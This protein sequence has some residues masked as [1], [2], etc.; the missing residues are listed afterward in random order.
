MRRVAL[1][2]WVAA[3]VVGAAGAPALLRTRCAGC[4][5]AAMQAGGLR[6][7][8]AAD[9][10]RG[11]Y[12]GA[13]IRPGDSRGSKL[14]TLITTGVES[15]GKVLKMPPA[16]AALT[17]AQVAE[18]RAW[19][20]AGARWPAGEGA[21]A[22]AKPAPASLW[23]LAPLRRP[24]LPVVA[25]RNP[26]DAFV[27]ARLNREGV[28][29]SP[30][31]PRAVLARRLHLDLTGLLPSPEQVQAFVDDAAP[32]AYEKVVDELLRSPHYGEKW[33]RHWLDLA[34]YAD[35]E[36]GV[37]DYARPFAW[38]YRDWVM[39]AFNRDLPFDRFTVEQ[40]AGDLLP[41]ATL[42]QK[43]ATGFHRQTVTSREGG[44]DLER[45]RFDQLVDR[46][47][48]T[49]AVFLGLTVGCAQCHDHKYD[50]ITQKDFYRL[51]AY[52]EN[53]AEADLEAPLP[54]ELG[55]YRSYAAA[56]REQ[57]RKLIAEYGIMPAE[58]DWEA[59]MRDA[60]ARPG[61]RPQWDVAYDAMTKLVDHGHRIL[62]TPVEQRTAREHESMVD[63][64][65]RYANKPL[66]KNADQ[67]K[68][69]E[70]DSKLGAL[71]KQYPY[72]S[73]VM[74]LAEAQAARQPTYLRVRGDFKQP[75]IEV[76]PGA[77][78]RLPGADRAGADRLSLARWLVLAENP[79]TA[80]VTV[81]RLWQELFGRGLVRTSE[82]F[83]RQGEKPSHPEL[84]DWLAA[85]FRERGWSV[86]HLVRLMVTSE[87]YRR[88]SDARPALAARDPGNTLL[89]RQVRMRLPAEF[90]R[91]A[92]LQA[93][94]LLMDEVGGESVRPPQP[95][96]VSDLQ[97]SFK[98][99]DTAGRARYRRGL[100][101]QIQRTAMYPLLMNFD[102]PDRLTACARRE[103][104]NTPL[105]PLNLMNDPVFAEAAQALAARVLAQ[106]A[107]ERVD[108]VFQICYGRR[109]RAAERDLVLSHLA[110]RTALATSDK[111]KEEAAWFGVS[112]AL[113][114]SDEFLTRE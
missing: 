82:D 102:A 60:A 10:L 33:A 71:H 90:I 4:H 40:M 48:N 2:L 51:L 100:Y 20:D 47:A 85:E 26:I 56:Y 101:I 58:A 22:A 5:G 39:D 64:F 42:A 27:Q 95:E 84:L 114:N 50:P 36:G 113:L 46:A 104:S 30:E 23:S 91:D 1:L 96:G 37:Q 12:S 108:H 80:R 16:G 88:S 6:L 109:P 63:H 73:T 94:G 65:T 52:F 67:L 35:S 11:G 97:Y 103:R 81:N 17:P 69:K 21:A 32:D 111:D 62:H 28:A 54:G 43:I 86:K 44:I 77:P 41:G 93:G 57:R 106:P 61:I 72:L 29:P 112:R 107:N 105:Q 68:L 8:N 18:V 83:G 34:R 78:E 66:V 110:R 15:G 79:L 99:E 25:K 3:G 92:A 14:M 9:G 38:R 55:V 45:L 19:I 70:L 98:W 13:V 59:Q 76:T 31:A 7:D 49:G 87:A 24:T 74:T 53:A 89:A 75:G